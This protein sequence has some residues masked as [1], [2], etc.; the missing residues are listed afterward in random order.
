M[1]ANSKKIRKSV[2]LNTSAGKVWQVLTEDAYTRKWYAAFNEG[3]RAITTWE[4]G[5][6]AVF[7]DEEGQGG[8]VGFIAENNPG[9]LLVIEYTANLVNGK[10][11]TESD[12]AKK[13]IGGREIY[14]LTEANGKTR[15]AIELD[16]DNEFFD[17]MDAAWD[18]ALEIF[19]ALAENN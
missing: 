1:N 4:K 12:T 19:K 7:T 8:I 6:K 13:F 14:T 10:E 9:K 17:F 3:S 16:M 15:L 2:E 5:S 11:D 18:K